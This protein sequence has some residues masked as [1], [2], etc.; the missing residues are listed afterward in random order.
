VSRFGARNPARLLIGTAAR[1]IYL[2][3]FATTA[4]VASQVLGNASSALAA[5]AP[6]TYA[7]HQGFDTCEGLTTGDL[8]AWYEDT[9]NWTVGLYLGGEDGAAVGCSAP[10]TTVWNYALSRGY[11]VEAFWYGAQ[12]P[13]SC[14][15]SSG[16][17]AY[18]SLNDNSA[19]AEGESEASAAA[20]QASRYGLPESAPIYADLE[21]FVNNSG[22]LAAAQSFVNGW[23]YEMNVLTAYAGD[24]YGSSCSSY[25]SDMAAHSNVPQAIAPDDGGVDVTGVYGLQCLSNSM[26]DHNQRV[27]QTENEVYHVFNGVG[28]YVDEDCA[29]GPVISSVGPPTTT[30]CGAPY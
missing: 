30:S 6:E 18:I 2:S 14:G 17:P 24:L 12:M 7:Y 19:T 23:E 4:L 22:C 5:G 10:G 15:G 16:R 3:I 28:L 25:L 27:H 8:S 1:W 29:D 11:G 20:A 26:W 13:T 9:P 21:G